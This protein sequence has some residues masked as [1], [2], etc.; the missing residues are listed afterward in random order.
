MST[1]FPSPNQHQSATSGGNVTADGNATVTARGI[2]WSSTNLTPTTSD[3]NV[4]NGN[5]L[6]NFNSALSGLTSGTTYNVTAY[7]TNSI[8]TAYSSVLSFKTLALA[9]VITTA[10]LLNITTTTATSGGNITNDGGSPVTA[11]GVCWSTNQN[12]SIADNKTI[13]GTGTGIFTSSII[14]LNSGATYYFRAYATN[15]IGTS[16]GNQVTTTTKEESILFE[17]SPF[18]GTLYVD[19]KSEV[20]PFTVKVLSKIPSSGI[21]YSVKMVQYDNSQIV[22][23]LDTTTVNN[24]VVLKLGKFLISKA[25]TITID[26][27][28]K[29]NPTNSATKTFPAKRNRV[30]KNYMKTSYEL[31][32]YD[33]WLSS[34]DIYSNGNHYTF[35]NP[36]LV[37]QTAQVDIDGDGLEDIITFDSYSLNI[38]PTPNPPPSIFINN[39]KNLNKIAWTGVTLKNPHGT[40]VLVGDFN[41]DSIPDLFSNVAVDQ[42]NGA[43]PNLKDFNNILFNSNSGFTRAKEFDDQLGFWYAGCSGDIDNDGDLDII[44]FNFHYQSNGV[45]SKILW[46]DGKGN[47]T[48]DDRGIGK[49]PVVDESELMDV[50][51]DGNLDLVIDYITATPNRTP[52]FTILWGNGQ[53][54]NLNNSTAFTL[55]EDQYLHDIDFAD[56]DSDGIQELILSGYDGN[57][58]KFWIEVYKSNDKG[59]TFINRT[60]DYIENSITY[61]RFDHLRVSDID[62]NG[63]LDIFAPDKRDNIRWEWNGSKFIKK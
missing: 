30:Y 33:M 16:Y 35:D 11:R 1:S 43:F 25:Y 48:Y 22:F 28:S 53:G 23:K 26:A 51:N 57:N 14:N 49:I 32:N 3:N 56:L 37:M 44:M 55:K 38:T 59:K 17:V 54:F 46:N 13:D 40:K 61:N 39:A 9:P 60:T 62:K 36:L 15:S 45:T 31:S 6:G 8:G 58:T 29:A 50:N 18:N 34:D 2:C 5:G 20:I 63:R 19:I 52:N 21:T 10:E 41:N 12:P 4:A 42:P 27:K 24:N 7:A 47:F